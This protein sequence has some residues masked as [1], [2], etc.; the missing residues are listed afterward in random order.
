MPSSDLLATP[1]LATL[2]ARSR[3]MNAGYLAD[4]RAL[5]DALDEHERV[6]LAKHLAQLAQTPATADGVVAALALVRAW[7]A[8]SSPGPSGG[9]GLPHKS[10]A[11][12]CQRATL[13]ACMLV[14]H[15]LLASALAARSS[16]S[17]TAALLRAIAPC[18]AHDRILL[19]QEIES[20]VGR[21]TYI[22]A[23]EENTRG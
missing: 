6:L 14:V 3:V 12:A 10:G 23:V 2:I 8:S 21:E 20:A 7:L 18:D 15:G 1:A 11:S 13:S 16:S 9:G 4:A 19:A 17:S 5:I 22:T